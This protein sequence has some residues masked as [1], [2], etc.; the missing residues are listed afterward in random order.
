MAFPTGTTIPTTN[1]NAGTDSP[2]SARADLLQAVE[3]VNDIIASANAENG[4]LVL[5][6]SGKIPNSVFP[7]QITLSA[8]VQVIN[9]QDGVVNIRDVLRL[10]P[11]IVS[12]INS[13]PSPEA[14][15]LVYASN[16]AGGNPCLAF[17]D[18]TAWKRITLG[19]T[20]SAT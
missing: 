3:A 9:P 8:G 2:A 17:Y 16:G 18:G 10:Q 15:D 12:N 1:L 13:I 11:Q 6:G 14:G 20:I 19:A 4:V 7:T 5:T